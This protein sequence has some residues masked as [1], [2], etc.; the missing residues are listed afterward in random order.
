MD[1]P[2]PPSK[3]AL[4]HQIRLLKDAL[5]TLQREQAATRLTS[6]ALSHPAITSTHTIIS[7]WPMPDEINTAPLNISLA[8]HGHDLYLPLM[9]DN[10]LHFHLF[11]GTN[12]LSPDPLYGILQPPP[13]SPTLPHDILSSGGANTVIITPGMAFTPDGRRLGRGRGF[14]DR[15]F[16]TLPNA[17]RIGVGFQCQLLDDLPTEPHDTSLHHIILA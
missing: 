10:T 4:R 12:T 14:Y 16:A 7:F 13:D 9:V 5:T 6:L 15:A 2:T 3:K 8:S 1:R 11:Q 17:I